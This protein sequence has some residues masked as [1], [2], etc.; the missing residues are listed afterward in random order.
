MPVFQQKNINVWRLDKKVSLQI[1]LRNEKQR[2]DLLKKYYKSD[3]HSFGS[4]FFV[5]FF[6]PLPQ[7]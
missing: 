6:V 1:S 5:S 2:V 4:R 3:Y 7:I